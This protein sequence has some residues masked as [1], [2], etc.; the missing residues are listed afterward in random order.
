MSLALM[1]AA[2]VNPARVQDFLKRR[3]PLVIQ[4]ED[5]RG[6]FTFRCF[7]SEDDSA[8]LRLRVRFYWSSRVN[9]WDYEIL[10]GA[11]P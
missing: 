10:R 2:R 3:F 11:Q 7:D 1:T 5:W 9:G 8:R 6:R 4:S